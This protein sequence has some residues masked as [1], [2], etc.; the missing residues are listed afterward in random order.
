M[1]L[2]AAN[3]RI[4]AVGQLAHGDAEAVNVRFRV[5]ADQILLQNL[6]TQIVEIVLN[7]ARI[8]VQLFGQR[9]LVDERNGV[10]EAAQVDLARLRYVDVVG[11]NATVNDVLGVQV[12]HGEQDGSGDVTQRLLVKYETRLLVGPVQ[13]NLLVVVQLVRETVRVNVVYV[14]I[15]NRVENVTARA[16]VRERIDEPYLS[17]VNE[18]VEQI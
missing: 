12:V 5:V 11:T 8:V 2:L 14:H 7:V 6:R 9:A 10:L 16:K 1:R 4:H 15:V 17:V 18:T 3:E 13:V